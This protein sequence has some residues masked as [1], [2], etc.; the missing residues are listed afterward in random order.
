MLRKTAYADSC[1]ATFM[2][3]LR[4]K[5]LKARRCAVSRY[6]HLCVELLR[7]KLEKLSHIKWEALSCL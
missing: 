5:R 7:D 6:G 2:S 3:L 4:K 1:N